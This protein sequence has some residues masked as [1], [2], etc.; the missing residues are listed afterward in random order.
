MP[1]EHEVFTA[2][3]HFTQHVLKRASRKRYQRIQER[4]SPQP[5]L[6]AAS[7]QPPPQQQQQQVMDVTQWCTKREGVEQDVMHA[8]AFVL[9]HMKQSL[10]EQAGTLEFE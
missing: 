7:Q 5:V 4:P 3:Q 9:K 8:A 10:S 2:A 1:W 6:S